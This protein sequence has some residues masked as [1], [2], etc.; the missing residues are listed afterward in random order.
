L[1]NTTYYWGVFASNATGTTWCEIRRFTTS[2]TPPLAAVPQTVWVE[3]G[4]ETVIK[5]NYT[6]GDASAKTAVITSL[7][8]QGQLYQYNNGVR[9]AI[10]S[11]VPVNVT[12]ANRNVIYLANGLYGNGAGNFN[13]RIHD[14][15]GD[16]P[17]SLVTVNVSPPG[18]P[19]LLYVARSSG[20]EMQF[21]RTMSNPAGRENQFTVLVNGS[22]VG[23]TT[24]AL[25]E[26]DPYTITALLATPLSGTETVT[27]S[28]TAGDITSEQGGWLLSFEAQPVTLLAQTITFNPLAPKQ[29]GDPPFSLSA[30]ANSGL[31]MTYSSSNLS[32]ATI[33]GSTCTIVSAGTSEIT[34]RQAGNATYA[35]ARYIRTLTVTEST[36]KTLYIT[37]VLL[38]G[39]YNGSGTMRQAYDELGPHWPSGVADHITVELHNA[40][41]YSTIE[42]VITSVPLS[43]TG[44]ATLTIPSN[45]NGSYYITIK[46][47][48]S[49][50]TTTSVPVSFSE[51]II[52]RSFGTPS[53]VFGN[54]VTLSY[55][56][57]YLIYAGDVNQDGFIDT[58]DYVGIDNDSYNYM[59]GYLVTDV[60]GNGMIDTNDYI[61]VDNNNYN[62]IGAAIPF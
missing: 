56:G 60:D 2:D 20:I 48:N 52:S 29:E 21:D 15:T 4:Q 57:R 58:Q 35:P 22:Q 41:S 18:I 6:G 50:E 54:N 36:L 14:N 28:Y 55:D 32:V 11:S 9:G 17:V 13:F 33:S 62:Y 5:L 38:Q 1:M 59:A 24:L 30:A 40:A 53:N 7:P 31:S 26:G 45:Y 47:R 34:A 10:I 25:K 39:L 46:H 23:V 44:T 37:N 3:Q 19:N 51:N 61:F 8:S 27:I 12:D 42:Y 43:T 49:L 16:S